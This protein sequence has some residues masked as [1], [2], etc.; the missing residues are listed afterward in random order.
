MKFKRRVVKGDV[1]WKLYARKQSSRAWF[2][3]SK[4]ITPDRNDVGARDA[5]GGNGVG[6]GWG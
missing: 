5:N 6:G 4:W 1:P 2:G 3:A